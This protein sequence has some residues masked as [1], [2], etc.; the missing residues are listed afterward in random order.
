MAVKQGGERSEQTKETNSGVEA[1]HNAQYT[2]EPTA[3]GVLFQNGMAECPNQTLA[4]FMRCMLHGAN[5]GLEFWSFALIHAVRIYSMLPHT[6]THQ[7]PYYSFTGTHPSAELLQVFGCRY[8]A[9]KSKDR[10]YKLDYNTSA[11]IFLG[12]TGTA[13][14]AHYYDIKTKRIKTSTHGIFD[15]ANITIPWRTRSS[16]SQALIDAGYTHDQVELDRHNTIMPTTPTA[17]IQ[18]RTPAAKIPTRC[19]AMS[20]GYDVYSTITVTLQPHLVT[21]IPLDIKIVP[22]PGTYIQI[23]P[24]SEL[25]TKGIKIYAGVI[26]P[27]YRGPISVLM[28]NSSD[29]KYQVHSGDRIV[30]LIFHNVTTPVLLQQD[31]LDTTNHAENGFGSTGNTED[32]PVC[33]TLHNTNMPYNIFLCTDPFDDVIKITIKDFGTHETMGLI[34]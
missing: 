25:A 9:R 2:M 15:E 24:R 6:A 33:R 12:F 20:V 30:Q 3:P 26:D 32:P 19:S 13:K 27:D 28:Y 29:Q 18:P 22:P 34:L 5:L 10:L 11:G 16:A 7:T 4:I 31:T 14:N 23:H 21:T 8:Y 17:N 1:V